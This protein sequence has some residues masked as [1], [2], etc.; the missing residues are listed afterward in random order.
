MAYLVRVYRLLL[1]LYPARFREEY[2][3]AMERQFADEYRD[4]TTP[5]ERFCFWLR[6]AVDLAR[7]LPVQAS[8]EIVQDVRYA[9]RIY[10]RRPLLTALSFTA[11]AMG[12]G[13]TT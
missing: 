4:L 2:T 8:R 11:L 12:I 7:S 9:G 5:R 3:S 10:G 13:A 6:T 1:R